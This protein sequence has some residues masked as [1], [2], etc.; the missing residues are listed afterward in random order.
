MR[1]NENFYCITKSRK[2]SKS[3]NVKFSKKY[4]HFGEIIRYLTID[5]LSQFFDSIENYYHKLMFQVLYELGCRVGEFV[6]IQVKH[7][8]FS[9]NTV[10]FPAENTK[11]KHPRTSYLPKGLMNEL[12]SMLKQKGMIT[13]RAGRIRKPDVYLFH[14]GPRWNQA[15]TENRIRQIFQSYIDK[16]DLQRTYSNDSLGR[17]L[18]MFTVHSLRHSHIIHY[19]IDRKVPLPIVQKQVGHRSLKTTSVYLRPSTEKMA[20]AYEKAALRS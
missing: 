8:N 4:E 17:S 9:R 19:V 5:E 2:R 11:T 20:E 15:Y 7:L 18:K 12:K 6:R 14:P 13:K 10:H 3:A 1:Q 16:A